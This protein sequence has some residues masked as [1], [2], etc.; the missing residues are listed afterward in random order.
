MSC[1]NNTDTLELD[2]TG[3]VLTGD[4][5]ID[6][7]PANALSSDA[8]GL[9][10][11]AQNETG[12]FDAG[13]TWVYA[14]ADA[15]S[16][17]FAVIGDKTARYSPGMRVRL[18][19]GGSYVYFI[20]TLVAYDAG[21]GLTTVTI[22]GGT[23]YTLANATITDNSFSWAKV[24]AGFPADMTLWTVSVIDTGDRSQAAPTNGT[25][26]NP[27]A[28]TMVIPPG[29]WQ[30]SYQVTVK[31]D[32]GGGNKVDG[33]ATFSTAANTESDAQW[34]AGNEQDDTDGTQT[35]TTATFFRAKVLSLTVKTS[36]FMNA[37]VKQ[38][39]GTSLVFQGATMAPTVLRA[40]CALL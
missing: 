18:K 25:W 38:N 27:G 5:R 1:T 14:G 10:V 15:P 30:V 20:M 32:Y 12:W 17:F 37:Q 3:G 28:V 23:T 39:G 26:Y 31:A 22:Y 34:T 4:V 16:F 21:S 33:R 8:S 13:E 7:D 11:I 19:Q 36:Y 40:I 2:V 29:V 35:R 9:F 6:P 24:P